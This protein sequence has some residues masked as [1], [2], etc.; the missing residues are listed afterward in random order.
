M[1]KSVFPLLSLCVIAT[2]A[3]AQAPPPAVVCE[4]HLNKVKPGM[5]AQYEQARI[6][7]MAWHKSQNDKWAWEVWQITTGENTGD[8]RVVSCG[9]DWKDFDGRE[10]FNQADAANANA[11]FVPY[12]VQDA[13]SYY[14][15]RPDLGPP[16]PTT[17]QP[18]QYLSVIFFTLK[19]EGM[20]DFNDGV[21]KVGA[22]LNKPGVPAGPASWYSLASG[23]VGPQVV[24]VQERKSMAAMAGPGKTLDEIVRDA[25]GDQGATILATLRK[26]YASTYSEL[27][28]FRPDLS[29]MPTQAAPR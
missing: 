15:L 16:P 24:L 11:T 3:V 21:K 22:A 25:Y 18:P 20:P 10:K 26:A 19:P 23:G 17:G 28:Q 8:Y 12:L 14:V 5:T 9:H 1:R 29:Y 13:M 6:K 7:H 4:V 2:L 27:L